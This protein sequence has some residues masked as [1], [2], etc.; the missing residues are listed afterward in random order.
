[1]SRPT[2]QIIQEDPWEPGRE[3]DLYHLWLTKN[4]EVMA[5]ITRQDKEP[6][7]WRGPFPFYRMP[8]ID[9][10]RALVILVLLA[11]CGLA[12]MMIARS[13]PLEWILSPARPAQAIE[14][15]NHAIR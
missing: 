14:G 3:D 6:V 12:S 1:M 10:Y 15:V 5:D 8:H 9:H 7:V 11:I 2:Y 4:P 13:V